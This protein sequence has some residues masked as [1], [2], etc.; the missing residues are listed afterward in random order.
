MA[1]PLS[2]GALV[3]RTLALLYNKPIIGVN[4]CVG[5]I[6]MGRVV[7]KAE[8]PTILYV[9]GGNTQVLAYSQNRYR[10]FGETIDIAVGNA[11]D[12]FARLCNLSNDPSPGYNIEQAAKKGTQYIELPYIVKGMDVS[13]SGILTHIEELVSGKKNSQTRKQRQCNAGK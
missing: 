2:V 9:S 4:H 13:F 7:T 10:I 1:G 6:E 8:N 5:H 11:L 12:R 3:C